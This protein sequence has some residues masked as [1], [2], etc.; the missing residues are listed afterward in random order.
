MLESTLEVIA[1]INRDSNPFDLRRLFPHLNAASY[2]P[3]D[4][5]GGDDGGDDDDEDDDDDDSDA[6]GD[7]K[8]KGGKEGFDKDAIKDPEKKRLHDEAKKHR[9]EAKAAKK[10]R[11]DLLREKQEREDKDKPELERLKGENET[12]KA[13]VAKLQERDLTN[14]V[15]SEFGMKYA[16]QFQD[17]ED[18]LDI[19]VRRHK[20]EVD[21]DGEVEGLDEAVKDLLAKKP[22]LAASGSKDSDEDDDSSGEPSGRRVG[23][24]GKK[25]GNA[26]Q[27]AL[28]KKYPALRR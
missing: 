24:K 22:Y 16:K 28:L 14:S 6:G 23:G 20:F 8:G 1:Q 21:D 10:E 9:L 13:E 3:D 4:D 27:E 18:A 2:A 19:L 12:L 26:D 5:K 17:A 7:D 15:K 11:D 25:K